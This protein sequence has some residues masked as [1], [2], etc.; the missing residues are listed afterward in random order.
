MTGPIGT[1]RPRRPA[2]TPAQGKEKKR[3]RES[4]DRMSIAKQNYRSIFA[5]CQSRPHTCQPGAS[6]FL[7]NF[8]VH[9][10]QHMRDCQWRWVVY[11]QHRSV[12]RIWKPE[13]YVILISLNNQTP[14]WAGLWYLC[15]TQLLLKAVH[16]FVRWK[17]GVEVSAIGLF[18][19][20]YFSSVISLCKLYNFSVICKIGQY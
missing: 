17:H 12:T 14:A 5:G 19:I 11:W 2:A 13:L 16:P 7:A 1:V 6:S 15:L 20:C 4:A 9:Q 3:E 8:I 10:V 18:L